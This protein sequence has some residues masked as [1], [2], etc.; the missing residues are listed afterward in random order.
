MAPIDGA[1][2]KLINNDKIFYIFLLVIFNFFR[3]K[4]EE[5]ITDRPSTIN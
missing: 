5:I 3:S 2:E 4:K 1:R